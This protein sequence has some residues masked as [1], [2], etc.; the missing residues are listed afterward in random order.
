[1]KKSFRFLALALCLTAC[2]RLLIPPERNTS[3][4][5]VFETLWRSIGEKYPFF[6][7]KAVDWDRVGE[8]Y[9]TQ[10]RPTMNGGELFT[11]LSRM[12]SELEDGHV[13]LTIPGPPTRRFSFYDSLQR[14]FPPNFNDSLVR[15][16]YLAGGRS[17]GP[18]SLR[19][20]D[21]NVAYVRYDK[22]GSK[23]DQ[24][25][26]DQFFDAL[27]GTKGVIFDVRDNPGGN[28]DNISALLSHLIT[29]PTT[30]AYSRTRNGPTPNDF[31][32]WVPNVVKP[33]GTPYAGRVAVLINRR[34]YS[35]AHLFAVFAA[36]LPQVTVVGGRSGGGSGA[37]SGGELPNGWT[38]RHSALDIVN[39]RYESDEN[40]LNPDVFE[41]LTPADVRAGRDAIIERARLEVLK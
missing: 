15:V 36:E 41:T 18:F 29:Q 37:P 28:L 1:M 40:G 14:R 8:R 38:F 17:I 7:L 35:A 39:T 33:R 5:A 32:A 13:D 11:L 21:G 3:P 31:S 10:L 19:V 27:T 30:V 23:L 34:S 6:S 24:A 9:R 2:E 16:R 22:F 12:L 26:F 25:V 20:L 4:D